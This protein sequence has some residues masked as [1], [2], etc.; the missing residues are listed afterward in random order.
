[1][2]CIVHN[3]NDCVML[4]IPYLTFS[5][6]YRFILGT[7]FCTNIFKLKQILQLNIIFIISYICSLI[8]SL[9]IYLTVDVAST[10]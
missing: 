7:R 3:M 2:Q 4:Y 6:L 5:S 10:L 1:M 8:L 9:D